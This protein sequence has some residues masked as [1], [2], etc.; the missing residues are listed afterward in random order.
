MT[1]AAEVRDLLDGC[2]ELYLGHQP[3]RDAE[4]PPHDLEAEKVVLGAVLW[5]DRRAS[6]L[7]LRPAWLWYPDNRCTW[8][9]L[10]AIEELGDAG[11]VAWG[12]CRVRPGPFRRRQLLPT[13]H[14]LGVGVDTRL[15]ARVLAQVGS[16]PLWYWERRLHQIMGYTGDPEECARIIRDKARERA[17]LGRMARI[18]R[19]L[20]NGEPPSWELVHGIVAGLL[21]MR[22]GHRRRE[23]EM[24]VRFVDSI[25]GAC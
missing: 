1:T 5:G 20:R 15:A 24:A 9:V 11:R 17:L 4:L 21:R 18:E 19:E 3:A 10:L 23:L 25:N 6:E 14:A 2:R 16:G 22:A 8:A 13:C 7:R 12:G